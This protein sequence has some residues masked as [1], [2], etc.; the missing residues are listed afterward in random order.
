M[1]LNCKIHLVP[2]IIVQPRPIFP[3]KAFLLLVPAF[4]VMR[5]RSLSQDLVRA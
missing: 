2:H 4:P 5:I 3:S 1:S